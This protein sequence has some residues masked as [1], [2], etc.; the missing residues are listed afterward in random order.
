MR[1]E[2]KKK[3]EEV[4]YS[5]GFSHGFEAYDTAYAMSA[6]EPAQKKAPKQSTQKQQQQAHDD[7]DFWT[8]AN[9]GPS[10]PVE[11]NHDQFAFSYDQP[12]EQP[13]H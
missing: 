8:S 9:S 7:D 1:R 13:K 4:D 6:S 3:K 10:K 5:K 2:K 11:T 12:K